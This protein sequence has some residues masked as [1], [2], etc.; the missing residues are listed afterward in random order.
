[1]ENAER[2]RRGSILVNLRA[3][4]LQAAKNVAQHTDFSHNCSSL[5]KSIRQWR[6]EKARP[7]R[8]V[9][10]TTTLFLSF[11]NDM[12]SKTIFYP[13]FSVCRLLLEVDGGGTYCGLV[14]VVGL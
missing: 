10:C 2:Q 4:S 8:R 3:E 9:Q 5:F 13:S 7:T 14:V 11:E 6:L 1:M 12:S